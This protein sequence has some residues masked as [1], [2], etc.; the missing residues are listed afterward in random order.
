VDLHRK[1][2]LSYD[3]QPGSPE[4]DQDQQGRKAGKARQYGALPQPVM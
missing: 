1:I 4:P 2:R 3:G